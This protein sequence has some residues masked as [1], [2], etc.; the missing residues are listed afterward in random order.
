M[1]VIVTGGAGFVGSA[2]TAALMSAGD[3]VVVIDDLSTG[4]RANLDVL[5]A[6]SGGTGGTAEGGGT[7]TFVQGS[8]LDRPLL[9]HT[10]TGA[11]GLVHLAAQVSV[12]ESVTNPRDT[13]EVNV[14]G[15]MNVLEAAARHRLPVVF[16]SS[17]SVYGSDTDPLQSESRP[18]RPASPY[19]ASKLAGEQFALVWQQCYGIP[20][21]ALR[22][23]NIFGPRQLPTDAYAAVVPA[24]ISRALAGRPLH[25]HGDGHQTR[26]FV[27]VATVA[28]VITQAVRD[29][30]GWPTPV[31]V[32]LGGSTS[33]LQLVD[34][35]ADQLGRPLVVQ[36]GP[37]RAG[38]IRT[39]RGDGTLLRRLFPTLQ[40]PDLRAALSETIDWFTT[41]APLSVVLP[42]GPLAQRT[43]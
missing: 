41:G 22:F 30:V 3:D 13:Y 37:A 12:P 42:D 4:R 20:A 6:G 21:L 26:D 43:N 36:H 28:Q 16:A 19:A 27:P 1:R 31:N 14:T 39:S 23:F 18:P 9:E 38:D 32:A 35:L 5:Q 29:R 25:I 40:P 11:T 10:F 33:L 7:L 2:V 34:H 15:T 24:F 8:V 17:A